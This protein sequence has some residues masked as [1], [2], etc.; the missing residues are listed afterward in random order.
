MTLDVSQHDGGAL[1]AW[2]EIL[3]LRKASFVPMVDQLQTAGIIHHMILD[4]RVDSESRVLEALETQQPNVAVERSEL[5][6]GECCRD[7]APRL[8]ELVGHAFDETFPKELGRVFGGPRGCSHLLTLFYQMASA[9]PRALDFEEAARAAQP[10]QRSPGERLFRRSI[11]VDGF[12]PDA[13]G[14]HLAISLMDYHSAPLEGGDRRLDLLGEHH[15]VRVLAHVGLA[16]LQFQSL[17][18]GERLRTRTTLDAPWHDRSDQVAGLVGRDIMPGL[19][20]ELRGLLGGRPEAARMLDA[21]LQL[22]PGFVQCTPALSDRMFDRVTAEQAQGV[23]HGMPKFLAAGGGTD[24]CYIW[25]QGGPLLQI[26]GGPAS[27][28]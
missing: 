12:E 4:G 9:L 8:Q 28:A 7:P 10:A 15:E 20:T 14:L 19:G 22:A 25:R 18:V 5:S 27:D 11:F 13:D 2:G 6:R 23:S 21:L 17:E 26:W 3:D 16:D 24:S 1:R